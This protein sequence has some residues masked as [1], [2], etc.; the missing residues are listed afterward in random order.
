M[1]RIGRAILRR[2]LGQKCFRITA[3][4]DINPQADNL[5]YQ[6][7][8]DTIYGAL[9]NRFVA[10]RD[11]LSRGGE[12]ITVSHHRAIDDVPW[13]ESG[14]DL[15]IDATG[16]L[17]NVLRARLLLERKGSTQHVIVTH[18]PDPVDFT[19][20]LGAN[21]EELDRKNHRLISSS[22]CDATALAPVLKTIRDRYG[23][24]NG[25]VTTLHP[26]LNYQ[27][28]SDGPAS[29]WSNPDKIYHHYALGRAAIGNMIP[30]PT[31]ALEA[32]CRVVDG[33]S[34]E[35]IGSFS[36]RTPTAIVG[37]ADITLNLENATDEED[38]RRTFREFEA[39][40]KWNII[41]NNEEP[42]VSSD[43][44]RSDYSSIVDHRWTKVVDGNVLKMVLW[45]DNEWGYSSRV[46]DQVNF[47][48]N[49]S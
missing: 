20:V 46:I 22:I 25:F 3:I 37:S 16:V 38:V 13:E 40:Q 14:V 49:K 44:C 12:S 29:S 34:E 2:N 4:N 23:I 7:N 19:M 47:I 42:L 10:E 27:N 30:K 1:G 43:F 21:E 6:L 26:W 39:T 28:L 5:A 17:N 24:R 36:Y 9:E 32:T 33:I 45:Y 15:V 41:H 18:S 11:V 31:S 35:M 48:M 8:Y